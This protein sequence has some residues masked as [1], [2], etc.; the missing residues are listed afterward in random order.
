MLNAKIADALKDYTLTD[1]ISSVQVSFSGEFEEKMERFIKQKQR[2]RKV[3]LLTQRVAL[4]AVITAFAVAWLYLMILPRNEGVLNP[5]S[6]SQQE[7]SSLEQEQSHDTP[8]DMSGDKTIALEP[9]PEPT[10]MLIIRNDEP[11]MGVDEDLRR[12]INSWDEAGDQASF[13]LLNPNEI[14]TLSD[15]H[16]STD[17]RF[18]ELL[19]TGENGSFPCVAALYY[20]SF[21]TDNPQTTDV[22][23]LYFFQYYL[24]SNR[25]IEMLSE[26]SWSVSSQIRGD[27]TIFMEAEPPEEIILHDIEALLYPFFLRNYDKSPGLNFLAIQWERNNVLFR[28]VVPTGYTAD[29]IPFTKN[30]LLTIAEL[31]IM[32]R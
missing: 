17:L 15:S 19:Q 30:D 5:L 2:N 14:P 20:V 25:N 6:P 7:G 12:G 31:I 1:T 26:D 27:Y 13:D 28:I 9:P 22:W 4:A 23:Y 29:L 3:I 24:G 10:G 8:Y 16:K 18:I 11:N 32:Q 21:Y